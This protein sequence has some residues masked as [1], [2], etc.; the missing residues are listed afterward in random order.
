MVLASVLVITASTSVVVFFC[1]GQCCPNDLLLRQ[2]THPPLHPSHHH[3]HHYQ[4]NSHRSP[5]DLIPHHHRNRNHHLPTLRKTTR[6]LEPTH[7]RDI[8]WMDIPHPLPW[9]PHHY[10]RHLAFSSFSLFV[11]CLLLPV[12]RSTPSIDLGERGMRPYEAWWG[13]AL[14][15]RT[16]RGVCCGQSRIRFLP[17]QPEAKTHV[18]GGSV[19]RS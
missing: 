7:T 18:A 15:V 9:R 16:K 8:N 3:L 4:S 14:M 2:Q 10:P 13:Q 12:P 6:Q 5:D 1:H 11:S 19:R 17:S